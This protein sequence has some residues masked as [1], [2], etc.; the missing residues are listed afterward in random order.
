MVVASY[1]AGDPVL[2]EKRK[3]PVESPACRGAPRVLIDDVA[4]LRL[5]DGCDHGHAQAAR[6]LSPVDRLDQ[7]PSGDG[8]VGDDEEVG[9]L[10]AHR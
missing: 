1:T 7:R 10:G 3:R 9:M 5:A 2:A 4:S 8:L 6:A